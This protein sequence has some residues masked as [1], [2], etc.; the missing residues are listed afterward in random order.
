MLD[1]LSL[2]AIPLAT[3]QACLASPDAL[4]AGCILDCPSG[5]FH[6][7]ASWPIPTP[8]SGLAADPLAGPEASGGPCTK[9]CRPGAWGDRFCRQLA[10]SGGHAAVPGAERVGC[11]DSIAN[12]PWAAAGLQT[13]VINLPREH[14]RICPK[15]VQQLLDGVKQGLLGLSGAASEAAFRGGGIENRKLPAGGVPQWGCV[16]HL[17][18]AFSSLGA[19][20]RGCAGTAA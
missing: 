18:A 12:S 4:R 16:G 13:R 19:C 10:P 2:C 5:P 20:A 1:A 3:T 15:H 17:E 14:Q 6:A 9:F 7:R 8:P 11:A